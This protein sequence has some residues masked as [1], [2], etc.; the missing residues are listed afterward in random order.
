M[1]NR[2]SGLG[3]SSDVI[4][5]VP[6]ICYYSVSQDIRS[7][8]GE[9]SIWSM[10]E[11]AAPSLLAPDPDLCHKQQ[12]RTARNDDEKTQHPITVL[13]PTVGV[14]VAIIG[15]FPRCSSDNT[16]S[17]DPSCCSRRCRSGSDAA[18]GHCSRYSRLLHNDA[19]H[20][21]PRTRL[22]LAQQQGIHHILVIACPRQ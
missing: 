22:Y 21:C 10:N 19:P 13:T 3:T 1:P 9:E 5:W 6:F 15:R 20:G 4:G 17:I 7:R 11:S 12:Q 2:W 8:Y 16:P 14:V 18:T